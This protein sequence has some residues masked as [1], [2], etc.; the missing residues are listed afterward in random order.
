MLLFFALMNNL[1][2]FLRIQQPY[3]WGAQSELLLGQY[4]IL[5]ISLI[6]SH[7]Q[8]T[9]EKV[10]NP[11]KYVWQYVAAVRESYTFLA[12]FMK[13]CCDHKWKNKLLEWAV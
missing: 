8:K 3:F 6:Y 9:F 1:L 2:C 11:L 13:L 4:Q 10:I 12:A 5:L 7:F